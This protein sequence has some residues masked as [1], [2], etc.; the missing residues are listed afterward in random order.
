VTTL[1]KRPYQG[2]AG[3]GSICLERDSR[4]PVPHYRNLADFRY[5]TTKWPRFN[6]PESAP[7]DTKTKG[8]VP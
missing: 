7:K 6:G 8:F 2:L 1:A 4:T 3:K 5:E